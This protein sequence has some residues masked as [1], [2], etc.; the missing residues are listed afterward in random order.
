MAGVLLVEEAGGRV[1]DY[2]GGDQ[3]QYD[4][5]GR[6]LA[7]NGHIHEAMIQVLTESFGE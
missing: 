2:R 1:T 6:Y 4:E 7:S 3:P 5:D